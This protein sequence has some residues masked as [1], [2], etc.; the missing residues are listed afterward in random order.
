MPISPASNVNEFH[1]TEDQVLAEIHGGCQWVSHSELLRRL[2][3]HTAGTRMP[4][5]EA[6]VY[7][8]LDALREKKGLIDQARRN[9]RAERPKMEMHYRRRA[10]R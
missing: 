9:N 5:N 2:R 6:T 4:V 3:R 7:Y 10:V 8:H 1:A